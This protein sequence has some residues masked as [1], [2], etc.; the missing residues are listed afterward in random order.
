MAANKDITTRTLRIVKTLAD[1]VVDLEQRVGGARSHATASAG[2]SYAR[3]CALIDAGR[4]RDI[5]VPLPPGRAR[6][7]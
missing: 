1:R 3:T 7:R 5:E 4:Q 2:S 6:T